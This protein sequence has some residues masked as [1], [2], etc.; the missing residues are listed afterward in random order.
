[1]SIC[2]N[3]ETKELEKAVSFNASRVVGIKD[4]YEQLDWKCT[5]FVCP[6]C[7]AEYYSEPDGSLGKNWNEK[8]WKGMKP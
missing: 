7:Q 8:N 1:M 5:C 2:S 3:C 4:A 6:N